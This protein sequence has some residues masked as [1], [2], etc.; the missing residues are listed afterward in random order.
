MSI[1]NK[2][3]VIIESLEDAVFEEDWSAVEAIIPNLYQVQDMIENDHTDWNF[4]SG[5][6]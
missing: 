5:D 1:S 4:D 2:I 6:Y 3:S